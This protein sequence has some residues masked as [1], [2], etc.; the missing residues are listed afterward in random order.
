L[1]TVE[2]VNNKRLKLNDD[3]EDEIDLSKGEDRERY[4]INKEGTYS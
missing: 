4:I 3:E 1:T 2:S